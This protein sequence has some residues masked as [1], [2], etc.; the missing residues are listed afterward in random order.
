MRHLLRFLA[1]RLFLIAVLRA[2]QA[3]EIALNSGR[4]TFEDESLLYTSIPGKIVLEEH[5]STSLFQ[6][7]YTTPFENFTNEIAYGTAVY[8]ADVRT[9]LNTTDIQERVHQM[10]LANISIS[11]VSLVPVGIQGIFNTTLAIEMATAVNDQLYADYKQGNY[12]DRFEFFCNVALQ[13]ATAAATELTRCVQDLGGVGV[14]VAGYTNNGSVNNLIYLDDPMY[15]PFW[16]ALVALD[17]PL[18]IHPRMP[19]P[20]QQRAY[21]GYEFLAGSS[22]GYAVETGIHSLR[23]MV[24]GLFDTYPTLQVILGHCGEGLPFVLARVD[25]RMRHYTR[26]LWPAKQTMSYYWKN[27]FYVTSAGVLDEA[28]ML[29]TIRVSGE[30]RVM[31]SVDYPFEDDVEISGWFD[32]IQMSRN[33]KEAIAF[34]NAKRLL[35][36]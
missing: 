12:S 10:D 2:A 4:P 20:D 3:Q 24:S 17:V 32:R 11:V 22:Y 19:A 33:I 25:Q 27:N 35:K 31:F 15:T 6:S 23:L 5:V 34:K 14:M 8:Q 30:D 7:A 1:Q 21:Q 16:E 28:A 18:Y 13:D 9:R 36:I 26:S 29:D